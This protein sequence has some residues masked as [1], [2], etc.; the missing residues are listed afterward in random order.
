MYTYIDTHMHLYVYVYDAITPRCLFK[1]KIYF[2]PVEVSRY[3]M[4]PGFVS[5]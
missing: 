5:Y 3:I 4:D 2:S 1:A